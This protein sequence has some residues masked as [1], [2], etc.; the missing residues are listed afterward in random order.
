MTPTLNQIQTWFNEFNAQVFKNALPNVPI[1]ITNNRRQ[2][3]QFYW[4]YDRGIGIKIS[5]YYDAPVD[6]FRNTLLHEMCHL[7]CYHRGFLHEHHG[8]NWQ[9]IARHATN[10]TG[11][12]IERTADISGIN[13]TKKNEKKQAEVIAKKEAPVVIVDLEYSDHHFIIKTTKNVI[14]KESNMDWHLNTVRPYKVYLCNGTDF[15]SFQSS[16]S[17]HRGY[18]YNPIDYEN[19]MIPRLKKGIEVTDLRSLYLGKYDN[20]LTK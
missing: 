18:S 1:K 4:G 10:I 15:K 12:V 13:P 3:G 14:M 7:Y 11:L 8:K 20:L 9:N 5:T 19:K 17:I 2:L 6:M 16:R